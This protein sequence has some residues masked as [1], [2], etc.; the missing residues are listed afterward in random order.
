MGWADPA[1]GTARSARAGAQL[2]ICRGLTGKADRNKLQL[3]S[4][5]AEAK[6]CRP[7]RWS[8]AVESCR[9]L[10]P[11]S[12][13]RPVMG[14]LY[15]PG[16]AKVSAVKQEGSTGEIRRFRAHTEPRRRL[17]AD[18]SD[19]ARVEIHEG[20]DI[21][22]A[23]RK[24]AFDG[25]RFSLPTARAIIQRQPRLQQTGYGVSLKTSLKVPY[26]ANSKAKAMGARFDMSRKQ[27]Y[28]P[29]GLDLSPFLSWVPGYDVDEWIKRRP[30]GLRMKNWLYFA[31]WMRFLN[32][33]RYSPYM[34]WWDP[35]PLTGEG[36]R[37]CGRHCRYCGKWDI[38]L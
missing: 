9:R 19:R 16:T 35:D 17:H 31:K 12:P 26:E 37:H 24:T 20:S 15:G 34:L 30:K 22:F 6:L 13:A 18:G 36:R 27:W 28:V 33:H 5:T 38:L 21:R 2:F 3:L 4:G 1:A 8:G 32:I 25:L 10:L 11:P 29:D 23:A 7:L 14:F